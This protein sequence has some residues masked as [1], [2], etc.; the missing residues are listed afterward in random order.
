[1]LD[2]APCLGWNHRHH[3]RI[4]FLTYWGSSKYLGVTVAIMA[5][6][7]LCGAQRVI[8]AIMAG[9]LAS[10]S[11]GGHRCHHGRP[12]PSWRPGGFRRPHGRIPYV[13]VSGFTVT[14]W[15]AVIH[16]AHQIFFTFPQLR[17]RR[18]R[19]CIW[20]TVPLYRLGLAVA[21]QI[22]IR[23]KQVR[24]QFPTTN[25]LDVIPPIVNGVQVVAHAWLQ[26]QVLQMRH[27]WQLKG[28]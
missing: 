18:R 22:C 26:E 10:Q 27:V 1:M 13:I 25:C 14:T 21:F 12:S 7:R 9:Y 2:S 28:A 24:K 4:I 5:G 11:P 19:C 23:N 17:E 3:G 6:R 20:R 16:G 15:P 8:V